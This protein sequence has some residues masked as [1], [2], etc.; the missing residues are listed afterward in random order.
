MARYY[1]PEHG[2]HVMQYGDDISEMEKTGWRL[3]QEGSTTSAQEAN[4]H[5]AKPRRARKTKEVA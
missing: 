2:Y 4:A 1:H 3:E 5:A